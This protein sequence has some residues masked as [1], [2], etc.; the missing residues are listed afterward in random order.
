MRAGL[1]GREVPH[2]GSVHAAFV[3]CA[4]H[5][6]SPAPTSLSL[7]VSN[8]EALGAAFGRGRAIR[9]GLLVVYTGSLLLCVSVPVGQVLAEPAQECCCCLGVSGS[10]GYPC[11][12]ELRVC[13]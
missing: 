1:W 3:D 8:S 4:L 2:V 10:A 12:S 5:L 6:L 9:G 13:V 11:D 7:G